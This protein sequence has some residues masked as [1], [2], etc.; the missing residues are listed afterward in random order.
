VYILPRLAALE[1]INFDREY[2]NHTPPFLF[3]FYMVFKYMNIVLEFDFFWRGGGLFP[4][5]NISIIK[6]NIMLIVII[7]QK[8]NTML[9]VGHTNP[10]AM[11]E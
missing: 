7:I 9:N 10:G 8:A 1:N 2:K 5:N 3:L 4:N 11:D 6:V